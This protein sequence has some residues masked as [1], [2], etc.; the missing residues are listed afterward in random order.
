MPTVLHEDFAASVVERIQHELSLIASH[1]DASAK[2]AKVIKY[3]GSGRIRFADPSYGSHEP[4]ALFRHP[5]ARYPGVVIEVSYSQKRVDL[6]RLA[7]DYI[8]GS[9]GNIRVVIGLDINYRGKMATLSVWRPRILTNDDGD[10][11]LL[12]EQTVADQVCLLMGLSYTCS[13]QSD[14]PRRKRQPQS[15]LRSRP[16]STS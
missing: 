14:I 16:A 11:V 3:G 6:P 13:H 7:D 2:F 5:R 9:N 1:E 4:D 12:A 10:K 15:G 8:L